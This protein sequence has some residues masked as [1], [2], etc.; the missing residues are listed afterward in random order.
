MSYGSPRERQAW[1]DYQKATARRRLWTLLITP[2]PLAPFVA[3]WA[4]TVRPES[5]AGQRWERVL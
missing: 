4:L 5:K 1:T 3:W 2:L